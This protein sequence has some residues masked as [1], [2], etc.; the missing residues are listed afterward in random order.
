V[1]DLQAVK[2]IV[3]FNAMQ[4]T[5]LNCNVD[6]WYCLSKASESRCCQLRR[7]QRPHYWR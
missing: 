1:I 4:A 5:G 7:A 3:D 6:A 2:S